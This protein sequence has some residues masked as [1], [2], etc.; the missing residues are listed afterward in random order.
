MGRRGEQKRGGKRKMGDLG[1]VG[2]KTRARK[3]KWAN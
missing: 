1:K 2:H 3:A